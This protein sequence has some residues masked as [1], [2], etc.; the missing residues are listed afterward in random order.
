M[1]ILLSPA[2]ALLALA[3]A[4]PAYAQTGTWNAADQYYD[5]AEMQAAKRQLQHGS[6]DTRHLFLMADR[7]E[8]HRD[9]DGS[10][11]LVWDAEGWYGG[12]IN[13]FWFKTEG[14]YDYADE[15]FEYAELQYLYSRAISRYFDLQA[16][17]RHDP[18]PESKGYAAFALHGLAPQWF[19]LDASVFFGEDG[20]TLG[21]FEAEYD[22]FLTQR[23]VLQP[24]MELNLRSQSDPEALQG[25][26]F[27]TGELGL[28]LRYDI[29]REVAPYI[30]VSWERKFGETADFAESAGE[31][32]SS[33]AFVAGLRL[34][35]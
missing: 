20:L 35:Y 7:F 5:P 28:R 11:L 6:G 25:S 1:R 2:F 15:S 3:F 33:T 24:R 26:G 8:Y 22:L 18:A 31:D 19:E 27:T 10:D 21:Y 17:F 30:G 29:V 4:A 14:T 32:V 9:D 34:W 23:L 13:R 16:G 12:D